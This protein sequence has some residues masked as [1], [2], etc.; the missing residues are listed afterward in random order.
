MPGTWRCLFTCCKATAEES[1]VSCLHG[2]GADGLLSFLTQTANAHLTILPLCPHHLV[3]ASPCR[4]RTQTKA[5]A[6]SAL[7]ANRLHLPLSVL[8]T[9]PRTCLKSGGAGGGVR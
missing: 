9:S 1:P 6:F 8:S 4:P 7:L 3:S 5:S 2:L